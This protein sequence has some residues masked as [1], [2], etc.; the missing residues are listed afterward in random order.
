MSVVWVVG[1]VER[2]LSRLIYTGGSTAWDRGQSKEGL[3]V[4]V[5][6]VYKEVIY[7]SENSHRKRINK[8]FQQRSWLGE[9]KGEGRQCGLSKISSQVVSSAPGPAEWVL[10]WSSPPPPPGS[11]L[12][13]WVWSHVCEVDGKGSAASDNGLENLAICSGVSSGWNTGTQRQCRAWNLT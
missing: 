10:C 12:Q 6:L 3:G 11:T 2:K 8:S 13:G 1:G 7:I 5:L 9:R 4:K